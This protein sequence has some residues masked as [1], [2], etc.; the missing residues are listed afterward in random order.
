MIT[1]RRPHILYLAH[2]VPYPPNRGDR[3]RS[4]HT[5]Q[6]LSR[7]ANVSLA[8][9]SD[10]PVE[11]ATVEHL[12][13]LATRVA[14]VPLASASRW[15]RGASSLLSG[16]TVTEGM[17]ASRHLRRL[18]ATWNA[19]TKFDA[20]LVFCSSMIQFLDQPGFED[21]PTIVDLVDVDSQKWLDYAATARGWRHWLYQREGQRLRRLEA[22]L[23]LRAKAITFVSQEE[24]DLFRQF[25]AS[26]AVYAVPNGVNVEYFCPQ[27][28]E[29]LSSS[30]RCVFVGALDYRPNVEGLNWFCQ[31]VWP[32][33]YRQLPEAEFLIVGRRP[34][35]AVKRLARIAGVRLVG[36]VADVRPHVATAR[37][38]IAPLQVARGVQNKVLEALAMGKAVIASPQALEGLGLRA[39]VHLVCASGAEQWTNDLVRLL[40]DA[41][42]CNRLGTA[43]RAHLEQHYR[44]D[45]ALRPL[46]PLLGTI[47]SS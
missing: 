1:T 45:N 43:A 39:D 19:E 11:S 14:I 33:V 31:N 22:S 2:R 18:V 13:E 10:E 27:P 36:E 6:F 30:R 47:P 38:A 29:H 46:L 42:Q 44:W 41:H 16:R 21:I 17:F 15:V 25:A 5:L 40:Q 26:D 12:Q 8:C 28:N 32:A 7:Y 9:L 37:V 35:A 4:F 20:V 3:I 23:P 24:V 34:T